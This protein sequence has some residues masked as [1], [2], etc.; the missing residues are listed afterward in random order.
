MFILLMIVFLSW[1]G[2]V[3]GFRVFSFFSWLFNHRHSQGAKLFLIWRTLNFRRAHEELFR[4]GEYIPLSISGTK[5]QH[6]CAFA[7]QLHGEAIVVV[8][9]RLLFSLTNG[10]EN[11]PFGREMWKDTAV[12]IPHLIRGKEYRD[13][14]TGGSVKPAGNGRHSAIAMS[15]MLK[16]FPVALLTREHSHQKRRS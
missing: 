9:P 2:S 12:E 15:D 4:D 10:V 3:L 5:C 7:R 8:V 11:F 16:L 13:V 6:V 1:R 14:L